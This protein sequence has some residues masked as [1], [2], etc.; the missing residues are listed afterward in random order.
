MGKNAIKLWIPAQGI[1]AVSKIPPKALTDLVK[2]PDSDWH[3]T[4]LVNPG[5]LAHLSDQHVLLKVIRH[6]GHPFPGISAYLKPEQ[7]HSAYPQGLLI[8]AIQGVATAEWL[9]EGRAKFR[10]GATGWHLFK[11][12]DS[13]PENLADREIYEKERSRIPEIVEME[14]PSGVKLGWPM[15]EDVG[16]D[17]FVD[18]ALKVYASCKA[19]FPREKAPIFYSLADKGL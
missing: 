15:R 1:E 9:A 14:V 5:Y 2:L 17:Y 4:D 3:T 18:A 10:A 19:N 12:K 8:S 7:S 13:P 16:I 6:S 11:S